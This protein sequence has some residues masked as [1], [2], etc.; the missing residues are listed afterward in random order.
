M[1]RYRQGF[2][3]KLAQEARRTQRTQRSSLSTQPITPMAHDI[4]MRTQ[5]Y[6]AEFD[7]V[8]VVPTACDGDD[9]VAGNL[10][11]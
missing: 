7:R 6:D 11:A 5:Y 9:V 2:M 3:D 10:G 8:M 1:N 4:P